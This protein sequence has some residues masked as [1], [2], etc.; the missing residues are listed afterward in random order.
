MKLR[1]LKTE[2]V[3]DGFTHG[4]V[5]RQNN[6][7]ILVRSKNGVEHFEVV[8]VKARKPNPNYPN[9]DGAELVEAY[10]SSED[11]GTFGFT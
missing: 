8:R 3:R 6:V 4:L 1:A 9:P 5:T 10:P 2:F 7:A 11:W